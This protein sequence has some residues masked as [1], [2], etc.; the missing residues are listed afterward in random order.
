MFPQSQSY[1]WKKSKNFAMNSYCWTYRYVCFVPAK[2]LIRDSSLMRNMPFTCRLWLVDCAIGNPHVISGQI[3]TMILMLADFNCM[4]VILQRLKSHTFNY[5]RDRGTRASPPQL[6]L[7]QK[8][9]TDIYNVRSP[10]PNGLLIMCYIRSISPSL[11]DMLLVIYKTKSHILVVLLAKLS[12]EKSRR[13][14]FPN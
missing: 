11:G 13:I 10:L 5:G 8:V 9:K 7:P 14:H 6:V 1:Y 3:A 12:A 2:G 4:I